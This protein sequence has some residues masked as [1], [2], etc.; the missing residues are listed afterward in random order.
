[1]GEGHVTCDLMGGSCDAMQLN[2]ASLTVRCTCICVPLCVA[3]TVL[4]CLSL[5]AREVVSSLLKPVDE[6]LQMSFLKLLSSLPQPPPS[7][8]QFL[9]LNPQL[10]LVYHP[11]VSNLVLRLRSRKEEEEEEEEEDGRQ[12]LGVDKMESVTDCILELLRSDLKACELTAKFFLECLKY[13]ASVLCEATGYRPSSRKSDS[14]KKTT[15]LCAGTSSALLESEA[16]PST[17]TGRAALVLYL[18]AAL[19]EDAELVVTILE[20]ISLPGLFAVAATIIGCH[21]HSVVAETLTETK[22]SPPSSSSSSGGVRLRVVAVG[23]GAN[24]E[25]P[26][27]TVSLS[28]V[29]GLLSAVLGGGREV[30]VTLPCYRRLHVLYTTLV[31]L[32]LGKLVAAHTIV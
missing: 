1:M 17:D 18:V 15:S 22:T 4:H 19:C 9:S 11:L 29:F 25:L 24:G 26:G 16:S 20:Q 28:V 32:P 3:L 27:G 30:C 13:L 5:Q 23:A 21:A 14:I 6:S 12:S 8:P 31:S 2:T 7:A 10:E